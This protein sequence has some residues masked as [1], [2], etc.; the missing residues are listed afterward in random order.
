MLLSLAGV[1]LADYFAAEQ[2][3]QIDDEVIAGRILSDTNRALA[4][5]VT[6][7]TEPAMERG[8]LIA[9][10][11]ETAETIMSG[12]S[13]RLL[14]LCNNAVL[15]A[16]EI[17]A[18]AVF[19]R[20]GNILAI[21]T[22][23]EDGTAIDPDRVA[24]IMS[25]DFS[26]RGII[27]RCLKNNTAQEI[28]EFQTTCDITPAFFDSSGLSVAHSVPVYDN[29]GQQVGVISTRLRF[30]RLTS[31]ISDRMK[32]QA[33]SLWFVTDQ[34]GFFDESINSGAEPPVRQEALASM[35]EPLITGDASSVRF[36]QNGN[37]FMLHRM[38]GLKTMDGGGIQAMISVPSELLWRETRYAA[39]LR[40]ALP[41]GGG[42]VFLLMAFLLRTI[43]RL[44]QTARQMS[45]ADLHRQAIAQQMRLFV[46]HTP[47]AVAMLDKE[48]RYVMVSDGWLKQYELE[49]IQIIG[50][51]HYDV[52][53]T[54]PER[55]K[56]I[57]RRVL[58]GEQL[59]ADRDSFEGQDGST[60]WVRW[61]L[62]PW[63]TAE[64]AV[65]GI[66]MFT[67]VITKQI[68]HEQDLQAAK[69]LAEEASRTKSEFLANMSHEIRTPMA[70]ILGYSDLL[71][72]DLADEPDQAADAIRTIQSNAN[73]LLTIIN[74][75]LDVSKIEAGQMA[76]EAIE[77][78]PAQII[79]EVLSL[80]RPRAAGKGVQV[81]VKYETPL[82]QHIQS[83]PTRLRQI[84]LNLMGNAIK[85][86]EVGSVTIHVS[87][88]P[89][90]QQM[91]L[92]VIDT[93]IGMSP[94]QCE[95]ISKFEAFS[96]A[97]AS[98]TRKFGGTGLGLRISNALAQMLG[99]GIEVSS[100]QGQG[101]NFTATI[102]TGNL[103]GVD[104]LQSAEAIIATPESPAKKQA[105]ARTTTDKPLAG[106]RV[107]LAEDGPDN[108]R[109]IG[110]HL[111]KAGAEVTICENGRIAVE[112]LENMGSDELPSVVLMDM[113][114][115][116]LDGY[117]A[118]RRLREGGFTLPI[119]ALTAHAME[120][121]RQ[122]CLDAGC[123]DY[124]T[125][126]IDKRVLVDTCSTWTIKPRLE[127]TS[128]GNTI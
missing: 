63:Y 9:S 40:I 45:E 18:I 24:R 95:I 68:E 114:M 84:L 11:P 71:D 96:Q 70:A 23:Y 58:A 21:N 1:R 35:I 37:S 77:T 86:T 125:K 53:P 13:H 26:E 124:L 44:R 46:E 52:F 122:K 8:R 56:Q 3:G 112:A 126:P 123:D 83:D 32:D 50:R 6:R 49:D 73:H 90:S 19:D 62:R 119:I 78:G 67:Q 118:T 94:E 22:I 85:F 108:Q 15:Q 60:I 113:Q 106:H 105:T 64:G 65:G 93:G 34:G 81:G 111:K 4:D 30:E 104:M 120:G 109:L 107:L 59:E 20:Q 99:G 103:D 101:S 16:T 92:S 87:C 41:A 51:S 2:S 28:L 74:D 29:D 12:D 127:N 82:P 38:T 110:F 57:H 121:D 79:S 102:A 88:E 48:M 116:E 66:I 17:D 91:K 72:G 89:A 33:A 5:S 27:T 55:W 47:A 25:R 36:N 80:V 42:L 14:E 128:L 10:S 98:T 39:A 117:S 31:L 76:V 100:V 54:V 43:S 61:N 97:D 115:P 69:D 75:I 7:V